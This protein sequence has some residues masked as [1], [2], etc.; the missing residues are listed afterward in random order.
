MG[1]VGLGGEALSGGGFGS[2][3][4]VGAGMAS[5]TVGMAAEG[6]LAATGI[7][8]LMG[9]LGVGRA[10]PDVGYRYFI[11]IEGISTVRFKE[12]SGMKMTTQVTTIR[13]GGNNHHE[14]A[15]IDGQTFDP[16]TIKKGFYGMRTEFFQWMAQLHAQKPHT[17]KDMSLVVLNDKGAEI[18]RFNFFKT[19]IMEYSGPDFDA[20]SK[21]IAFE[22]IKIHYDYFE[23]ESASLAKVLGQEALAAGMGMLANSLH[24]G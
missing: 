22:S 11:E 1:I 24:G 19:F 15:L 13:E 9:K 21:E 14:H 2:G 23:I 20:Q 4:Q 10:D 5:G 7:S 3:G 18:C 6:A 17:R 16:L 12:V 8:G